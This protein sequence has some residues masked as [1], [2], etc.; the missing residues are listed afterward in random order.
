[1]TPWAA[2]TLVDIQVNLFRGYYDG[3]SA[4][5]V[6]PDG[7]RSS[8]TLLPPPIESL[9]TAAG[10]QEH[11]RQ[12]FEWL[13]QGVE[14]S[15][16]RGRE[17][18]DVPFPPAPDSPLRM[19]FRL[20]P[21]LQATVLH[22]LPWETLYDPVRQEFLSLG[23][24]FARLMRVRAARSWPVAERPL[25]LLLGAGPAADTLAATGS[26]VAGLENVPGENGLQVISVDDPLTLDRLKA[27]QQ[28]GYHVLHLRARAASQG[29][30][31]GLTLAGVGGNEEWVSGAR[32]AAA[33][34]G[35][36]GKAPALVYW[37]APADAGGSA[38][39]VP[40]TL[41][42][43][44]LEA[45][46]QAVLTVPAGPALAPFT[47]RFYEVFLATG[48]PDVAVAVARAAVHAQDQWEWT[49][50]ILYVRTGD[51]QLFHPSLV[52]P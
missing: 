49:Y 26:P 15:Y 36:T 25:R 32:L 17:W 4:E 18:F 7:D 30:E 9:R 12:L 40:G 3:F 28:P 8:W 34:G 11:G 51:A 38:G 27:E 45:G 35:G 16:R 29:T 39:P 13:F 5:I 50:P 47:R 43:G 37:E 41:P 52:S 19:R 46:V 2:E 48:T 23:L 14:D 42:V 1:M 21:D 6:L 24:A 20:C 10:P 31:S 22:D 33:L 44:M